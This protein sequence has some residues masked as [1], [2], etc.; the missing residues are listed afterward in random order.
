ML[1]TRSY[2]AKYTL[3]YLECRKIL[4]V[5]YVVCKYTP[6]IVTNSHG[7]KGTNPNSRMDTSATD[8]CVHFNMR[9]ATIPTNTRNLPPSYKHFHTHFSTTTAHLWHNLSIAISF[10]TISLSGPGQLSRYKTY[11]Y[12]RPDTTISIVSRLLL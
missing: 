5:L 10:V 3:K 7:D 1:Q 6:S 12:F 2:T 11:V 4:H 8:A 9:T